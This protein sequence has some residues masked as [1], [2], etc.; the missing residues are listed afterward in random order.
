MNTCPAILKQFS[1]DEYGQNW[2]EFGAS[3]PYNTKVGEFEIDGLPEED[4]IPTK[5]Q[6]LEAVRQKDSDVTA[7]VKLNQDKYYLYDDVGTLIYAVIL[8]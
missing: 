8:G 2:Y 7:I 6:I 1:F 5:E 4:S 3:E